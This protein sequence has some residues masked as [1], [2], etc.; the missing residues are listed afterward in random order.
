MLNSPAKLLVI[1]I[2]L[3][4]AQSLTKGWFR[5]IPSFRWADVADKNEIGKGNVGSVM[6]ICHS[7]CTEE[8]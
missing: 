4:D 8:L 3:L 5:D 1:K 6:T 7:V 2:P